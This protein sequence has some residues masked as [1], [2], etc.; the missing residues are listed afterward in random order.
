MTT[1]STA[2]RTPGQLKVIGLG[3][4]RT[5]TISLS[6]ALEKLGFGPCYHPLRIP[7]H[8]NPWKVFTKAAKGGSTPEELDA[9]FQNYSAAVDNPV[10]TIAASLYEAYP[11]AKFILVRYTSYI[12]HLRSHNLRFVQT[13]RDPVK[14]VASLQKTVI[15]VLYA[16]YNDRKHKVAQGTA[17]EAERQLAAAWDAIGASDWLEMGRLE[18]DPEGELKRH[19]EYIMKLIPSEKLLVY[20][21][22]EGWQP[23]ADFLGVP[24]PEEPFP[25]IN[26]AEEFQSERKEWKASE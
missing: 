17:T 19:N 24:V 4:G 1:E 3:L 6:V 16:G 9:I 25:H 14:W 7:V 23:L 10:A 2:R 26:N 8:E 21:V 13:T 5:G 22:T 15:G 18:T 20:D 11:E 12:S